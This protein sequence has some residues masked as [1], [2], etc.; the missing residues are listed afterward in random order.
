M[1]TQVLPTMAFPPKRRCYGA[2]AVRRITWLQARV[3]AL[4]VVA[5]AAGG[6]AQAASRNVLL[7]IGDDIGIDAAEFYPTPDRRATTPPAPPTPNL[8]RLARNGVLF[9]SAWAN[10]LCVPTRAT[11]LTGRYG[12]RTGIGTNHSTENTNLPQLALGEF[13]LPEAFKTRPDLGY[14]LAH[15]G[16]WHVS[17]GTNDPNRYGWPYFAGPDTWRSG[18]PSYFSWTK[19]VNSTSNRSTTYATTDQ[20][21]EALGVIRRAKGQGKPYFLEVAFNAGHEPFHKPPNALHSKDGLPRYMSGMDRRPYYEAMVEALDTEIGRL[22]DGVDLATTTVIYISDNGTSADVIAAPNSGSK[23]KGTVYQG[24]IRVPLLVAGAG[25]VSPGR[26]ATGLVNTVDL[27]PS[28]LELAGINPETA[29]PSGVKIDGVSL[30]PHLR[31][32]A[33]TATRSWAYAEKFRTNYNDSHHRAIRNARYKLIE[34]AFGGREF[35]DLVEDPHETRNLL[36]GTLTST[37]RTNLTN[38]EQQIDRLLA[39][40]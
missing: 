5:V 13:I 40:R 6:T 23:A 37:Q 36:G 3:A 17:R 34:R 11:I 30:V 8:S 16:K 35:Y 4:L 21:N 39:T 12:F 28:I 9:R 19:W 2:G 10:P 29:V 1:T 38:L 25:V 31:S 27:F 24:G 7:L 22:L 32:E 18:L 15:V 14:V 20:V 33:G 26:T